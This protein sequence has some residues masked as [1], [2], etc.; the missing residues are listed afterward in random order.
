MNKSI[1]EKPSDTKDNRERD[2]PKMRLVDKKT[3]EETGR[4]YGLS[5]ERIRQIE[6]EAKQKLIKK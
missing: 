2:I 4:M 3:L 1:K 5:R 6:K